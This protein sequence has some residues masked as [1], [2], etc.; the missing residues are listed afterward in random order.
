MLRLL[1][2]PLALLVMGLPVAATAAPQGKQVDGGPAPTQATAI[3][4]GTAYADDVSPGEARW[5]SVDAK[6]GQQI[7]ATLT[8]YGDTQYGCCLKI[9]L[10]DPDFNRVRSDSSYNSDG[11]A[12]TLRAETDE[13]GV[14]DAGSYY[15]SVELS[16][17]DARRPVSFDFAV[18]V[19]GEGLL[20]T[21]SS[22]TS[23][24]T[25]TPTGASSA[26]A[27]PTADAAS[28]T[29]AADSGSGNTLL[30]G[31]VGAL[32]LLLLLLLAMVVLLLRRVR[33]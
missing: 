18:D 2:L 26:S 7:G 33:Q 12:Q 13:E 8:E 19:D 1:A 16:D 17:E 11:I 15:L 21:S 24:P 3:E 30:W 32:A 31:V 10:S 14:D 9:E 20:T 22:P 6:T 23:E 28:A 5:F 25:A 27:S 29:A 4:A